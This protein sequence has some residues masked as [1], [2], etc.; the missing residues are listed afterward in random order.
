MSTPHARTKLLAA[1]AAAALPALALSAAHAAPWPLF[2]ADEGHSGHRPAGR[3]PV[4]P[5]YAK[6]AEGDRGVQT[7]IIV[8]DGPQ[9]SQRIVYGTANG[10]VHVRMLESGAAIGPEEGVAIDDGDADADVFTGRGGSVTPV[11]ISP[12]GGVGQAY[13]IHN[14]DNSGGTNDLAV[15]QVDETTGALVQDIRIPGSKDYTISSSPVASPAAAGSRDRVLFFVAND[16]TKTS[17]FRVPIARADSQDATIGPS[18]SR[19]VTGGNPLASPAVVT[20]NDASGAPTSY[21]AVGTSSVNTVQTFTVSGIEPT[22]AGTE[23]GPRSG[24]LGGVAQTPSVP[25][26]L[27]ATIRVAVTVE[28]TGTVVHTLTQNGNDQRLTDAAASPRLEGAAAPAL[29]LTGASV[30]VTTAANLYLLDAADLSLNSSLSPG[31]LVGGTGFART[32]AAGGGSLVH[33]SRDNGQQ[34]VLSLRDGRPLAGGGFRENR[35][36]A[37][38]TSS[39]GQPSVASGFVQYGSD[40]GVF[41]YRT[42]CGNPISGTPSGE[43]LGGTTAGDELR[44]LGGNDRLDGRLGDDCLSGGGGHDRIS[45]GSGADRLTGGRGDD[46]LSASRGGKDSIRCGAGT[47]VVRADS[48]D[49]VSRDCERVRRPR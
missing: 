18:S 46:R 27:P 25:P 35:G 4:E 43:T 48:S 38:V 44:G 5:V 42:R 22:P 33:V 31:P 45:G 9:S 19:E 16:G 28:D 30:A 26:A 24:N 6:T 49:T 23:V 10:R 40:R 15:A 47:D 39:Y 37:D 12:P 3:A 1:L 7:S 17:L 8:T 14:D 29:A 34:L 21:V 13:V 32:T 36:N 11:D 2:G 20:F 41:V